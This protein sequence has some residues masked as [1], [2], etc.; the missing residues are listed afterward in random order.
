[1]IAAIYLVYHC[2]SL[3]CSSY[4]GRSRRL[5]SAIPSSSSTLHSSEGSQVESEKPKI[6][7]IH[8]FVAFLFLS[9]TK[10]SL[11]TMFTMRVTEL[12]DSTE[13]AKTRDV[14]YFAGDLTFSDP[15]Y[16]V[17]YGIMAILI[18]VFI[19]ILP[20]LLLLGPIQFIDWLIDKRGF[21]CLQRVWPSVTVHTFLDTFQ[22]F[23][24]PNRRFFSGI[25]FLFRLAVFL[26]YS[27]SGTIISQYLFQQV[28]VMVLIVLVAL[29]RP[30]TKDFYN[31]LD[32]LILFNLGTLNALALYIFS[33]K[34]SQ[35]PYKVYIVECIFVWLPFIYIVCYAVWNRTYK[36]RWYNSFKQKLLHLVN[37]AR[38]LQERG[39]DEEELMKNANN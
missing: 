7:L 2:K 8:A 23:Y 24:K 30:Y 33:N 18:L 16:L 38:L 21:R 39:T 19:V 3:K 22:G 12:F 34:S 4:K 15:N 37:P 36:R 31:Y 14:I 13:V 35:F 17:P 20:L 9:Y 10:F 1:M 6:T 26:N 29:F 11:A 5:R 25:Y 32:V 28:A 27:F